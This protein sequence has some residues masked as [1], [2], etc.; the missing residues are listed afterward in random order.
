M[1]LTSPS[2][3]RQLLGA[4]GLQPDRGFGQ[5]FLVDAHALDA[6]VTAA[7]IQADQTVVEF[8]P[9]LGVLTQQ[10]A[11]RAGRVVAVELDRRLLPVL[12]ETL[13]GSGNV[14]LLHQDALEFDYS[15]LPEGSSLVAN[16]PYNV[17]TPL[18]M[19][20]LESGRIGRIVAMVQREVAERIRASPG[21]SGFG[22]FSLLMRYYASARIVRDV[23]PGSFYPPPEVTSSIVRLDAHAGVRPDPQLF[24]LIHDAF[25]HRRK[26]LRKN[27]IMAGYGAE[28]AARALEALELDSRIRAEEL[29][30]ESFRSLRRVLLSGD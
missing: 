30:L 19:A 12:K 5:N 24:D 18:I 14:E 2:R 23:A 8:G 7:D 17:A 20:A 22:A 28:D 4:H 6:V 15:V 10:L 21:E 1:P 26:T 27:L 25:R 29:S 3:V 16:L 9:G 11:G 13:A